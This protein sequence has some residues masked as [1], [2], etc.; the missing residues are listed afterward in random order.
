MDGERVA[1]PRERAARAR[2]A[3]AGRKRGEHAILFGVLAPR[4]C[5]GM[6]RGEGRGAIQVGPLCP[7]AQNTFSRTAV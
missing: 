6:T 7:N 2:R 3:R 1:R 4:P 5:C